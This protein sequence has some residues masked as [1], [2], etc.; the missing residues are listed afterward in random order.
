MAAVFNGFLINLDFITVILLFLLVVAS[1]IDLRTR[2]IPNFITI[3]GALLGLLLTTLTGRLSFI[4]A[5]M[6][7]FVPGFI[8][9][10]IA[11]IS[12]G[13]IG[14]GDVKLL[15]TIGSFIGWRMALSSLFWG[16]VVGSLVSVLLIL[17][18]K[19]KKS[20]PVPFGPFLTIGVI[21]SLSGLVI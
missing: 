19:K 5:L 11:L 20:D 13:G 9:L 6:G 12:K 10:L 17:L 1:I 8:M 2:L 7:I 21:F 15:A 16:S 3:P 18:R 4:Q 14:G